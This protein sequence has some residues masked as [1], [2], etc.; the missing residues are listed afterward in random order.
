MFYPDYIVSLLCYIAKAR[1]S[2]CDINICVFLH[3]Q[4]LCQR[5]D[6]SKCICHPT[7]SSSPLS[8]VFSKA[9]VLLLLICCLLLLILFVGVL[10]LVL[11]LLSSI[12]CQS[13]FAITRAGWFALTVF[14]MSCESQCPVALPL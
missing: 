3:Q 12:L 9:V 14:L 5:F 11:V 4:S 6:T 2:P 10:C 13:N 8:A 7:P 1:K